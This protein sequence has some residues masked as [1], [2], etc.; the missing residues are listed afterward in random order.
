MTDRNE[1]ERLLAA[2]T[3]GPWGIAAY[4]TGTGP[5]ER[6]HGMIVSD[7]DWPTG[8]IDENESPTSDSLSHDLALI[9]FLRNNAQHYL[10]LMGEVDRLRNR[11]AMIDKLRGSEGCSVEIIHDNPDPGGSNC[12]IYVTS[13]FG[14]D[15]TAHYG[16]TVDDC[17]RQALGETHD[18]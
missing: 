18:N 2:A 14:E 7:G 10:S 1:L 5:D 4:Y 15:Y 13:N 3:E 12:A 17:L 11:W 9:C 6:C 16:D 8:V